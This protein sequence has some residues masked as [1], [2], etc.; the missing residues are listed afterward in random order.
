[1]LV[2]NCCRLQH[3]FCNQVSWAQSVNNAGKELRDF[4]I[5]LANVEDE[6]DIGEHFLIMTSQKV[7]TERWN[8]RHAHVSLSS[9]ISRPILSTTKTFIPW[10]NRRLWRCLS[11]LTRTWGIVGR[12]YRHYSIATLPLQFQQCSLKAVANRKTASKIGFEHET[13]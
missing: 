6:F 3:L 4:P 10:R 1:M 12:V 13:R 7:A 5:L 8:N 11:L 9:A 2:Q